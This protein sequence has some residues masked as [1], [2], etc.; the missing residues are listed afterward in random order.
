MSDSETYGVVLGPSEQKRIERFKTEH[1][2]GESNSK[3]LGRL[4]D[5]GLIAWL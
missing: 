1:M 2:A 4:I 5:R 3:V